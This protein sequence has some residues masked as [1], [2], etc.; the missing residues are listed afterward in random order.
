M[1]DRYVV[2][3]PR[4]APETYAYLTESF[5]SLPDV[6]EV[7]LDRRA[8]SPEVRRLVERRGGEHRFESDAFGCRLIKLESPAADA[9][10]S[11]A[12]PVPPLR[13]GPSA[14][15]RLRLR[16]VSGRRDP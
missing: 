16:Q 14:P 12:G 15:S 11:N 3:V 5:R 2:I 13:S 8:H 9:K 4:S 7:V 10:A 1:A 6:I